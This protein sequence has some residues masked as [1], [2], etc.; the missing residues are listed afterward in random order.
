DRGVTQRDAALDE[1]DDDSRAAGEFAQ[2][3]F[4]QGGVAEHYS[5]PSSLGASHFSPS[6]LSSL[7]ASA[8]LVCRIENWASI[9]ARFNAA[10]SLRSVHTSSV[11][12]SLPRLQPRP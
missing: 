12:A 5:T 9:S 2:R 6:A 3:D 11:M 1:D 8:C 10:F 4:A 7:I